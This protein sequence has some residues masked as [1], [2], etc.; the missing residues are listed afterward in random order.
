MTEL[1]GETL[2]VDAQRR[3]QDLVKRATHERQRGLDPDVL[4]D[5]KGMC[6]VDDDNVR[7]AYSAISVALKSKHS[8]VRVPNTTNRK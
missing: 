5:I 3:V 7:T 2:D 4:R 8:Q 1:A 6:K